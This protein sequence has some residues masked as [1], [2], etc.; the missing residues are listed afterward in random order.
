M[1]LSPG[2]CAGIGT[3]IACLMIRQLLRHTLP[4]A[5]ANQRRLR[6][7]IWSLCLADVFTSLPFSSKASLFCPTSVLYSSSAFQATRSC[8]SIPRR[9]DCSIPSPRPNRKTPRSVR[10][11]ADF[12]ALSP[13]P[14]SHNLP[15]AQRHREN[16][17]PPHL[18]ALTLI[19]ES[20]GRPPQ[21]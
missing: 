12:K 20:L 2:L 8:L 16:L 21:Y 5:G 15:L 9:S 1:L 17:L 14:V 13:G 18:G 7:L 6:E 4:R 11:L 10:W 3:G 19:A